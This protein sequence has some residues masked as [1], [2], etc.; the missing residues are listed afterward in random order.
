MLFAITTVHAQDNEIAFPFKKGTV[1]ICSSK[2]F[3]V[4]GYG[5]NEVIIR[6]MQDQYAFGEYSY[7]VL[8]STGTDTLQG[9]AKELA[10][11][12][13]VYSRALPRRADQKPAK[14]AI[15]SYVKARR[16][17]KDTLYSTA[18]L[19]FQAATGFFK[20][21]TLKADVVET[22]PLAYTFFNRDK[23][24]SKGLTKLGSKAT[25]RDKGIYLTVEQNED[26]LVI[27][28]DNT[29][30]FVMTNHSYEIM[31]PNTSKLVWNSADCKIPRGLTYMGKS[32]ELKDFKG[33]V[34]I[35]SQLNDLKLKDVTGPVAIN[36]IGA[37]VTVE[38]VESV[39]SKLYSIYSNNG[40]IDISLPSKSGVSIDAQ[41]REIFS[42]L[43]V[44]IEYEVLTGN[45]QHLKMK[46]NKAGVKMILD[47]GLGNIYLRKNN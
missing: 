27:R 35:S 14:E 24:R 3:K 47:A 39:P 26:E 16:A 13:G 12:V 4:I 5:G 29:D 34:E 7:G 21:D 10:R 11:A 20:G 1:K 46:L 2:N 44:E 36:T 33:E 38:F 40:F 15:G 19:R 6:S 8:T 18:P 45:T 31:I 42:D 22:S 30:L 37:N 32:W 25:N 28:D 17:S 9:D 41:G 43:P 23:S